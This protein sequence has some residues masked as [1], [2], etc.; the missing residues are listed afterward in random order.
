MLSAEE[1]NLLTQTDAD[2]LMGTYFR[3]FWQPVALSEEL[4][5]PDG[6]PV[7]VT[8]MGEELVAFRDTEGRIGLIGRRC[9]HRGADLFFGRNE[10]C[11]LR[12][13]YHGW[14]F[15]ISGKAVELPNVEPGVPLHDSVR[16]ASYPTREYGEIVW[17][18]LGPPDDIPEVPKLEFGLMP[19]E[20]RFVSK[21]LAECNWAQVVE[22]DLDASH[23]SF[24]H[25]LAPSVTSPDNPYA[26]FDIHRLQV[27][28]KN[29]IPTIHILD[30]DTGFVVGWAR[31]AEE[32]GTYWRTTQFMLPAH[33]TGPA[34]LPGETYF[35]FTVVPIIDQAC[36]IFVY[37]WNTE[38]DIGP[39]ERAKLDKGHAIIAE[40]GPDYVPVRNR[41]NDFQINRVVQKN[42]TF[43]GVQGLAEQDLMIQ[44]SQGFIADRTAE[45]LTATDAA[46]VKFRRTLVDAA[47]V[48]CEGHEPEAP[49]L[50]EAYHRRPGSHYAAD[51]IPL[52]EVLFERFG[53]PRGQMSAPDQN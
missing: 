11:G 41:S 17:A 1:N 43:T 23:F 51:G 25:M 30:H 45:C 3:R 37:A 35:G 19:P 48:L 34:A 47:R 24:L 12:C 28:R 38:R 32:E 4:T 33:G 5:E 22:G 53:H 50:A 40:R 8:I 27:I 49:R 44:Q 13:V 14:K 10:E 46:V 20:R 29:P 21:Q 39:K 6:P 26:P 36:W 2:T 18:W 7:R 31:N 52:E 16:V 15:D 9:P 42:Q